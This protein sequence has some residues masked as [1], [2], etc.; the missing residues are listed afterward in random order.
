GKTPPTY[1]LNAIGRAAGERV[2]L[3]GTL[4]ASL[5][6]EHWPI[7]RTTPEAD[8]LQ[9]L[10]A[11]MRDAGAT[12]VAMEV[13]SHALDQHRVDGTWFAAAC[14]T[15]LTHDHLDYHRT[16]DAYFEAKAR[17]FTPSFTTRAAVCI[18]DAYGRLL[19]ER[20]R[21]SPLTLCTYG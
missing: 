6:G 1:L 14:F 21:A 5:A 2:G 19:A 9:S 12:R 4:G 8:E 11:R 15:N 18:D 7:E 10:L 20:V 3:V 17:L 16:I 13:S